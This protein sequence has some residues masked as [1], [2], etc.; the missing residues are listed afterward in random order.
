M[1]QMFDKSPSS[2]SSSGRVHRGPRSTC[3]EAQQQFYL[4]HF[5][6]KAK[7]FK[8]SNC[9]NKKCIEYQNAK[10]KQDFH[11]AHILRTF[12]TELVS[13][14]PGGKL[15]DAL[16][17]VLF[18]APLPPS[19]T[20]PPSP[21]N[22][23]TKSSK[24]RKIVSVSPSKEDEDNESVDSSPATVKVKAEVEVEASAKPKPTT[25]DFMEADLKIAYD[26][27]RERKSKLPEICSTFLSDPDNFAKGSPPPISNFASLDHFRKSKNAD[28]LKFLNQLPAQYHALWDEIGL[29]KYFPH[30]M[31]RRV[32]PI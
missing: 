5:P 17:A 15:S 25:Y 2:S 20:P 21:A 23:R 22:P 13:L 31:S 12:L 28:F 26:I 9:I 16:Q 10:G 24:K 27:N 6:S 19:V 4:S 7:S 3:N 18:D 1:N 14:N 11:K 30:T 29:N 32:N 8:L